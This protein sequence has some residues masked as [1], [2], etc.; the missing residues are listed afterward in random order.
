[1][2]FHVTTNTVINL[3]FTVLVILLIIGLM[4]LYV[5]KVQY[6]ILKYHIDPGIYIENSEGSFIN[7]NTFPFTRRLVEIGGVFFNGRIK[8]KI[9]NINDIHSVLNEIQNAFSGNFI[10]TNTF[11]DGD[12]NIFIVRVTKV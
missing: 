6:Y 11:Y 8:Y 9:D 4:M 3:T 2:D 7:E 10:Q 1:M 5:Y 12:N